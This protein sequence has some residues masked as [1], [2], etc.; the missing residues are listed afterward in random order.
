M[1]AMLRILRTLRNRALRIKVLL[2]LPDDPGTVGPDDP[3]WDTEATLKLERITTPEHVEAD[4]PESV[5]AWV[6][7]SLE[8]ALD[9]PAHVG[10]KLGDHLA[11]KLAEEYWWAHASESIQ[12]YDA[13]IDRLERSRDAAHHAMDLLMVSDGS[14]L[15][16]PNE[17]CD[18]V[19]WLGNVRHPEQEPC[20]SCGGPSVRWTERHLVRPDIVKEIVDDIGPATSQ[21]HYD[22]IM[23]LAAAKSFM[24]LEPEPVVLTSHEGKV[25]ANGTLIAE[26]GEGEIVPIPN[27]SPMGPARTAIWAVLPVLQSDYPAKF[28]LANGIMAK[29]LGDAA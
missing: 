22:F 16:C 10:E 11:E 1:T 15:H 3:R 2:Y 27:V 12:F 5:H 9:E 7:F 19:E 21:V 29:A 13:L 4:D 8:G 17:A 18:L 20:P 24:A 25:W 14:L 28:K 6:R 26:V 23:A